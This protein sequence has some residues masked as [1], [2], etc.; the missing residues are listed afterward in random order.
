MLS[1]AAKSLLMMSAISP[2]CIIY[3]L[4]AFLQGNIAYGVIAAIIFFLIVSGVRCFIWI[5]RTKFQ[6]TSY[7]TTSVETADSENLSFMLLYLLPL[8]E[9]GISKPNLSITLFAV[10]IYGW[11]I[12]SGYGYHFNPVLALFK[13]HYFKVNTEEGV[14]YILISKK[15]F[16][17]GEQNLTVIQL[18]EYIILDIGE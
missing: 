4:A 1:K 6:K 8:F 11:V 16:S 15:A 5:C 2:I 10:G 13:L 9:N 14:T 17:K 18:T 7:K 3:S 12:W